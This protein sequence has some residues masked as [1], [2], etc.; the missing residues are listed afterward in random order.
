MT[1]SWFLLIILTQNHTLRS[2][3]YWKYSPTK[4]ALDCS[5]NSPCQHLR[6]CIEN[7][8]ERMHTDARVQRIKATLEMMLFRVS[9][10][11]ISLITT[12]YQL[13]QCFLISNFFQSPVKPTQRIALNLC[14]VTQSSYYS[15]LNSD[16]TCFIIC[17]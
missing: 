5:T 4:E 13:I 11:I 3:E 2:Q 1:S 16:S 9:P 12:F 10:E 14:A 6:K 8:M 17:S 7:G 15:L